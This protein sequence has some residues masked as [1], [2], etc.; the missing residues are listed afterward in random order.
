MGVGSGDSAEK[1][2]LNT[3]LQQNEN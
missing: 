3:Q 1:N 2:K